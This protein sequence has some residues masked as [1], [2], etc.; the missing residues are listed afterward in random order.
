VSPAA[1]DASTS[2]PGLFPRAEVLAYDPQ[3]TRPIGHAFWKG[4]IL[5]VRQVEFRAEHVTLAP[6]NEVRVH[7]SNQN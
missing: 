5:R 6:R 4:D 7:F 3:N 1:E 2:F